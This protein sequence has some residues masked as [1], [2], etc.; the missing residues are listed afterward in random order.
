MTLKVALKLLRTFSIFH[1]FLSKKNYGIL[2]CVAKS[3]VD[4]FE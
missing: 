4:Q 3:K 2:A 1:N